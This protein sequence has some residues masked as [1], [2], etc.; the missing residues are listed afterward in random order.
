M[1]IPSSSPDLADENPVIQAFI[2]QPGKV[3]RP[4]TYHVPY[5]QAWLW[6]MQSL[7]KNKLESINNKLT[8][9]VVIVILELIVGLLVACHIL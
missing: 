6:Y 4:V 5:D 7:Q 1:T 3:D 2:S 9:F 8:F